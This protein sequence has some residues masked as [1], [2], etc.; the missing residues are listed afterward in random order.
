VIAP[1][2]ASVSATSSDGH[3]QPTRDLQP[4]SKLLY[5]ENA[6]RPGMF[7]R[8]AFPY[9]DLRAKQPRSI[10][11]VFFCHPPSVKFEEFETD[12][13]EHLFEKIDQRE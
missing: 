3:R 2:L 7:F 5:G 12:Y 11:K 6:E 13:Y 1:Q 8:S 10:V 9:K 4:V